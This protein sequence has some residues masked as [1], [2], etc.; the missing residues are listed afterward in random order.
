MQVKVEVDYPVHHLDYLDL[1]VG[2]IWMLVM[3]KYQI[4]TR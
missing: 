2:L 1:L 4:L 3:I